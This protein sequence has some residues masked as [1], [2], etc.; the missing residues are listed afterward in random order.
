METVYKDFTD[1]E[2]MATS[3]VQDANAPVEIHLD[4]QELPDICEAASAEF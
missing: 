2:F 4:K 1:E 3:N